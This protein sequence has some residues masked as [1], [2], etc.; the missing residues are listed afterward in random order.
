MRVEKRS[1]KWGEDRNYLSVGSRDCM[2]MSNERMHTAATAAASRNRSYM[3]ALRIAK[4]MA[5][6]YEIKGSCR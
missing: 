5:R 3:H 1:E 6:T 4:P 2:T